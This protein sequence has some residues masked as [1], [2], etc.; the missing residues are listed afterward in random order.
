MQIGPVNISKKGWIAAGVLGTAMVTT[1]MSCRTNGPGEISVVYDTFGGTLDR[2]HGEGAFL[3]IPFIQSNIRY[4]ATTQVVKET[5]KSQTKDNITIETDV[6]VEWE[7]NRDA[8]GKIHR[9]IV[10]SSTHTDKSSNEAD[11]LHNYISNPRNLAFYTKTIRSRLRNTLGDVV[12][13]YTA[14][15]ANDNRDNLTNALRKGFTPPGATEHVPSLSEQVNNELVTIKDVFV[16]N[17]HLPSNLEDAMK[18]RAEALVEQQ[19]AANKI[20]VEKNN[21]L[22]ELQKGI[23]AANKVREEAAGKADAI[24]KIGDA[25][26]K[27]PEMIEYMRAEAQKLA[28]ERGGLIITNGSQTPNILIQPGKK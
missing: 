6:V 27:N 13:Q 11:D 23:A 7:L 15:D 1:P 22:A 9:E 20:Q 3:V 16:R 19:T 17:V 18:K 12:K 24:S 25:L 10:G 28:G 5:V 21:A 8:I 14:E 26:R 2:T 4:D